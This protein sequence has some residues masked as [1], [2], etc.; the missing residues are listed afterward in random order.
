MI[1]W[2]DAMMR[3]VSLVGGKRVLVITSLSG[4]QGA[5]LCCGD[6]ILKILKVAVVAPTRKSMSKRLGD[7]ESGSGTGG[8]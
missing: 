1:V 2:V 5:I 3:I 6:L 4:G 7:A 8:G